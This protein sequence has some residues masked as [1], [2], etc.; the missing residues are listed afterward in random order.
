MLA[1]ELGLLDGVPAELVLFVVRGGEVEEDGGGLEDG[2]AFVGDGGDAAVG[3]DLRSG[4]DQPW[5]KK[6][7]GSVS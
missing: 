2:E 3:V 5:E 4:F 6:R 1:V 7:R